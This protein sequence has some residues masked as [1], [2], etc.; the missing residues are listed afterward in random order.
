MA[1]TPG[2]RTGEAPPR[3]A[4]PMSTFVPLDIGFPQHWRVRQL[5]RGVAFY[6]HI[7]ALCYC[8]AYLTDGVVNRG[9]IAAWMRD[10]SLTRSALTLL[11]SSGLWLPNS[12]SAEG[13]YVIHDWLDYN[14]SAEEVESRSVSAKERGKLGGRPRKNLPA[15]SVKTH[16]RAETETETETEQSTKVSGGGW[17]GEI[18]VSPKNKTTQQG[19]Q[20]CVAAWTSATGTTVTELIGDN[21]NDAIAACGAAWVLDAI[22]L[23]GEAGARTWRYTQAILDRWQREGRDVAKPS[24]NGTSPPANHVVTPEEARASWL[25]WKERNEPTPEELAELQARSLRMLEEERREIA[26]RSAEKRQNGH[27]PVGG[28]RVGEMP[29]LQI[30][31]AAADG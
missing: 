2:G 31:P 15:L 27:H 11:E 22:R 4:P 23:S 13:G 16:S 3:E 7:L 26:A 6:A 28:G 9:V 1:R 24:K 19:F 20:D 8:K 30:L 21:I 17:T 29:K 25:E 18:G 10:G 14:R 12:F 5:G